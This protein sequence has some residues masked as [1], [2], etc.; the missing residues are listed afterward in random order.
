MKRK[1]FDGEMEED[2]RRQQ[3][4]FRW[5]STGWLILHSRLCVIWRRTTSSSF[6]FIA[7]IF[8]RRVACNGTTSSS[9][10]L[11][12]VTRDYFIRIETSSGLHFCA[13]L[14]FISVYFIAYPDLLCFAT[15]P[16]AH[17][18]G[19]WSSATSLTRRSRG[20]AWL[21]LWN[22]FCTELLKPLV[23]HMPL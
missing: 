19:T 22:N 23:L 17:P 5:S 16:R 12:L 3:R 4:T 8:R 1:P 6:R 11:R 9:R 7:R 20:H 13:L 21:E 18:S 10:L 14:F 2:Q 15:H